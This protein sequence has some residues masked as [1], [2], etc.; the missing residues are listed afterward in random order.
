MCAETTL[1]SLFLIWSSSPLPPMLPH[2]L[3]LSCLI[4]QSPTSHV[5]TCSHLLCLYAHI[6]L[7]IWYGPVWQPQRPLQPPKSLWEQILTQTLN[8]WPQLP[9]Y[10]CAYRLYGAGPLAASE[11]TACT[12]LETK[13][14]FRF[15]ISDP[16]Y[17]PVSSHKG[18]V[19][20][21]YRITE[22]YQLNS[23]AVAS[24]PLC[25]WTGMG[26]SFD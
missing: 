24:Y 8:Q 3:L 9:T 13:S 14:D 20:L 21:Q 19:R 22:N 7:L 5:T 18:P 10:P 23:L 25:S 2:L 11:A 16:N 17:R 12:S 26:R 6:I 15:E 1:T 4:E